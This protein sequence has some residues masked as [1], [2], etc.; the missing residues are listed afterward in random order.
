VPQLDRT[1]VAGDTKV[2]ITK[3]RLKE[4]IKEEL[5]RTLNEV[6]PYD[7]PP[8]P[9]ITSYGKPIDQDLSRRM[10]T[11]RVTKEEL[12]TYLSSPEMKELRLMSRHN[13]LNW[14]QGKRLEKMQKMYPD[15][16]E[17]ELTAFATY[18]FKGLDQLLKSDK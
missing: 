5:S 13:F 2:K 1:R 6:I 4:I 12:L 17:D 10:N 14:A 8:G 9:P 16:P 7:D 3:Q 15:V 11:G 18:V